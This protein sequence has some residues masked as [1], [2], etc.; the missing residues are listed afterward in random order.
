MSAPTGSGTLPHRLVTNIKTP[1]GRSGP[2][3][4]L[5]GIASS[6]G[7]PSS[8]R[9][10][11][12]LIIVEF[13]TR[14]LHIGFAGDAV[15]RGTVWFGPDQQR[16]VGD[17]RAWEG[18]HRDDWQKRAANDQW[19]RDHELWQPDIRGL[20]LGLV[21]DKIERAMRDALTK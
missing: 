16:R 15:P 7:S 11:E 19:G 14:K 10:D 2:S 12:D 18:T 4:P 21:G 13:G 1:G 20:D 8:L 9:A 6:F 5:R 17:F 3:T